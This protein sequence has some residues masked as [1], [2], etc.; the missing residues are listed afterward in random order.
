MYEKLKAKKEQMSTQPL[1][2]VA[3]DGDYSNL[4]N[5]SDGGSGYVSNNIDWAEASGYYKKR[6]KS[7]PLQGKGLESNFLKDVSNFIPDK[8][9]W[10]EASSY[11]KKQKK[12]APLQGRGLEKNLF[13]ELQADRPDYGKKL[14]IPENLSE[15]IQGGFGIDMSKLSLFESPEVAKMGAKAAAQGNIIRFA[16]GEYKPDTTEGLKTLGHELNHIRE[17]AQGNIQAN[18]EGTNIHFDPVHEA[19][20]DRVGEA[21]ASGALSD[22]T[23]V[24]M[25]S[26]VVNSAVVQ[27]IWPFRPRRKAASK[28]GLLNVGSEPY[29]DDFIGPRQQDPNADI[30]RQLPI[31]R[32]PITSRTEPYPDGFIG[33]RQQDPNADITRQFPFL[34]PPIIEGDA[35][36]TPDT[37]HNT[38]STR[39]SERLEG[40]LS[41]SEEGARFTSVAEGHTTILDNGNK[42][43][44]DTADTAL[45]TYGGLTIA[46][47]GTDGSWGGVNGFTMEEVNEARRNGLD[48]DRWLQGFNY[49][50]SGVTENINQFA[51]D[52]EINFTQYE[53]DALAD[54]LFNIGPNLLTQTRGDGTPSWWFVETMLEDGFF[55]DN[56]TQ[57]QEDQFMH[58]LGNII[59]MQRENAQGRNENYRAEG[60]W[61]RRMSQAGVFLGH[62]GENGEYLR[63]NHVPG[64]NSETD[65][66]GLRG[67]ADEWLRAN[68][69]MTT[70]WGHPREPRIERP[71]VPG[72]QGE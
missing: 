62:H 21:F 12:S 16:P 69:H 3:N 6:E 11:Y 57:E 38:P 54:M 63:I 14:N 27:G 55:T 17:Q 23:P 50:G 67:R 26:V 22:A 28:K 39:S 68:G 30:S 47:R 37:E 45:T 71:L 49:F 5:M 25:G 20:C 1:L 29:P 52:N 4:H 34:R 31:L 33:P 24:S 35:R 40:P 61:A 15:S 43:V 2:R 46:R 7:A 8:I 48:P 19:S 9:D 32:P 56:R 53:F 59:A 72:R 41:I 18:V 60:L 42:K 70:G 51:A 58:D 10:A 66:A 44:Y 13:G 64:D 36:G 65:Y